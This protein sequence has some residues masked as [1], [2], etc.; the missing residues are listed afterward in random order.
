MARW[1][2]LADR[3]HAVSVRQRKH[4][5]EVFSAL[6]GPAHIIMTQ[7]ELSVQCV[8]AQIWDLESKS[9]VDELKPTFDKDF[10]KKAQVGY[11]KP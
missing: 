3:V 10:G 1:A 11:P 8:S 7:L 9:I 5:C 2:C 4:A 6:P